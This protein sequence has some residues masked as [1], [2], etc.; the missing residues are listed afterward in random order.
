MAISQDTQSERD[1]V[2]RRLDNL[3]PAR[4]A[5][6]ETWM[7]GKGQA[8]VQQTIPARAS[9][10]PL[11]L[12]FA[13]ERMWFVSRLLPGVPLYNM[14]GPARLSGRLK[15]ELL[16]RSLAAVIA[17]HEPLRTVFP[18]IDG[19]PAQVV[20]PAGA[21]SLSVEDLSA[22]PDDA[23]QA[24]VT[25]VA[26]E[27]AREEFDLA[28]GPLLRLRLLRLAEEDHVM[29]LTVH[30]IIADGWSIR[31]LVGEAWSYYLALTQ[32]RVPTL[33][34]LP[35]QYA[36]FAAWQRASLRGEMLDGELDYWTQR[37]RGAPALL[38]L[39]TDQP[40]AAAPS[41]AGAVHA[42][43]ISPGLSESIRAFSRRESMTPFMTLLAAFNVLLFRHSQQEDV[44]VGTPVLGRNWPEVEG[45]IGCFLNT[46]PL[47]TDLGGNPS[48]RELLRRVRESALGAFAHQALPFERLVQ[49]LQPERNLGQSPIFQVMFNLRADEEEG[50]QQ[51]G[52]LASARLLPR[53]AS[54][55]AQVDLALEL[56]DRRDGF[57]GALEYRTALFD[58]ETIA[59]M[60][61]Q[62]EI[63]LQAIL[64]EP[65]CRIAS[66]PLMSTAETHDRDAS[67]KSAGHLLPVPGGLHQVFEAQAAWSPDAI[68]LVYEGERLSYAE[69]NQRADQIARRLRARGVGPEDRV[70]LWT[71]RGPDLVAGLLGILKA[72]GACV[73]IER[74]TPAARGGGMLK[75]ASA[76]LLVTQRSLATELPD[77]LPPALCLEDV[78]H[79]DGGIRDALGPP[80]TKDN[81]AYVIYTSGSTGNPKGVAVPHGEAVA[82]LDGIRRA[83]ALDD[84]DV[85]L[86]FAS[87]AFDVAIE[88][89]LATLCSGGRLVMRSAD[90][91]PPR[92]FVTKARELELTV[93]NLPP[94]YWSLVTAN[95]GSG[96]EP[97]LALRLMVV[98]GDVLPPA[99]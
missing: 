23:R 73:P 63:L 85:V 34:P 16:E 25:R 70:G 69:L 3:S 50:L 74:L 2:R 68:A 4:R 14:S 75:D 82:H 81:L 44:E 26:S 6:L 98:G 19:R 30:H 84:R 76:A 89:V 13:Q 86:Q 91:W 80:A 37:L 22:L 62:F 77:G 31:L 35:V 5:L 11:P 17:R 27:E 57:L 55:T 53:V 10:G 83:F 64:K 47:R 59:R 65:D 61:G 32:G 99:A 15:V 58:K 40:R 8:R 42:F 20:R 39:P 66:L 36:D 97:P 92:Q 78:G 56:V 29:L 48:F 88:Q 54:G 21:V 49:A 24:E 41:Y 28:T 96:P 87:I 95:L 9:D 1:Q 18:M 45:L 94:S 38:D 93:A 90:M 52:G 33:P 12:S 46:V 43:S 60:A 71:D 7:Q 51:T 79:T 72:G 67:S